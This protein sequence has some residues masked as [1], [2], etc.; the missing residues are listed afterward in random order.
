MWRIL[1]TWH[2]NDLNV[3]REI[4]FRTYRYKNSFFPHAI[5][6]WNIFISHFEDFPSFDS[7]KDHV[8]SL[9]RPKKKSIFGV[10]DPI[11][12][13][14][15]FQLR[16]SL[17][18]LR[19]HKSRHNFIDTPSDICHCN[20]GVEDTSHFLFFC[21]SY[22]T[23]RATLTTSVNEILL[24]NNLNNLEN[25]SQLYLYGHDSINFT[26]NRKI[27][28]STLKYIKDTRRFST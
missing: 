5:Y 6:S 2:S 16:V 9:F 7:L 26:D 14:Y 23:Q 20:Q 4:K 28:I 8:L 17:S 3:F 19:S 21:P 1:L 15:L 24:K 13:R 27:L 18:P 22:V 11:G 12:L 10:H 25:Q